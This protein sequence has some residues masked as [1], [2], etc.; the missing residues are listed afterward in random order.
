MGS[1][2]KKIGGE[3]GIKEGF[4]RVFQFPNRCMFN[5]VVVKWQM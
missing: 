4:L 2:N 3:S 1:Q 5:L